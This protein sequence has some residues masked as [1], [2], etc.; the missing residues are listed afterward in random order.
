M[1]ELGDLSC[2]SNLCDSVECCVSATNQFFGFIWEVIPVFH[3]SCSG[4]DAS[5]GGHLCVSPTWGRPKA[6]LVLM[7]EHK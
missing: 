3:S 1:V 5:R 7:G 4:S 2:L 6:G